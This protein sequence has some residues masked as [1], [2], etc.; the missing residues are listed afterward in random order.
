VNLITQDLKAMVEAGALH[1]LQRRCKT[2]DALLPYVVR[3]AQDGQPEMFNTFLSTATA[4]GERGYPWCRIAPHAVRL[5]CEASP[6]VIILA[7]PHI[8]W[9][10]LTGDSVQRWTT[11]ASEFPYTEEVRQSVVDALLHIASLSEPSPHIPISVWSWLTKQP[12]LPP[13]S[14]G[15]F[16][17]TH[18]H[19]VKAVR[20]LDDIEILKSYLLLIWSEWDIIRPD[21][22]DE[23]C[24]SIREDFGGIGMGRHRAALIQHLDHVL[25]QL[26]RGLGYLQQQNPDLGEPRLQEMKR[27]YG[28][29]E[30]V[31]L[32]VERRT[33]SPMAVL[34]DELTQVE[35]HRI[36]RDVYVCSSSP[37]SVVSWLGH[38]VLAVDPLLRCTSSLLLSTRLIFLAFPCYLPAVLRVVPVGTVLSSGSPR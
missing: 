35:M 16:L 26:D 24:V 9:R 38:S 4:S 10:Y 22:L 17:G 21:G 8:P 28:K 19:V 30:E 3:R 33:S 32:E 1:I 2:I 36:S 27:Q 15:C 34:F 11:A 37:V 23:I 13:S 29:F 6:R 25:G 14:W 31:L 7:S 12:S 5:L 20:R 18:V